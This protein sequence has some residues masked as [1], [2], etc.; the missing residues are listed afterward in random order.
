VAGG[1]RRPDGPVGEADGPANPPTEAWPAPD[2]AAGTDQAAPG[3]VRPRRRSAT[4]ALLTDRTTAQSDQLRRFIILEIIIVL[5]VSLG[6]AGVY[7]IVNLIDKLTLPTPLG[8]Q[9]TSMNPSVTPDRPWLDL[10]Y[11][12][13]YF[14]LP[15]A[16]VL[17]ALYLL[18][19]AYGRARRLIGFD[20]TNWWRDLGKGAAICAAV[21]VPGIGFYFLAHWLGIN[22][23]VSP[24]NLTAVWWAVPVYLI[25]ALLSGLQEEVIMLGYLVTRLRE[26]TWA[27]WLAIVVSALI[28]GSYHLYQGFG[29]FLGNLVM[30]LVFGY[31]FLRWRRVLPLVLAHFLMDAVVYVGT[32]LLAPYVSWF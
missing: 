4:A 31:L 27:P 3:P 21:G 17:L 28:R 26:L 13:Y 15:A 29:G 11:Q 14:I 23:T 22:T 2:A 30:G 5:A 24:A 10:A 12:L 9:T 32:A 7:A 19:L 8:D 16:E 18:H 20:L 1:V 25:S 6:R